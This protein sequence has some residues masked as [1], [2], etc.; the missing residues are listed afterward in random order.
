MWR[1]RVDWDN[2]SNLS[3]I[4]GVDKFSKI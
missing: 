4:P 2:G 1:V 3:L